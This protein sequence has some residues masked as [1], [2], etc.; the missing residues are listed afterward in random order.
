MK[1]LAVKEPWQMTKKEYVLKPIEALKEQEKKEIQPFSEKIYGR[2]VT[3]Y[4]T[5]NYKAVE[6]RMEFEHKQA[7]QQSLSEGKP[8]PPEVLED[9]PDLLYE[10]GFKEVFPK[11]V[12]TPTRE[13]ME[14]NPG[15]KMIKGEEVADYVIGLGED[16]DSPIIDQI[17]K[18]GFILKTLNIQDI[19]NNDPHVAKVV[20]TELSEPFSYKNIDSP[21]VINSKGEVLDGEHRL[22]AKIKQGDATINAYI[23]QAKRKGHLTKEYRT[24]LSAKYAQEA[25]EEEFKKEHLK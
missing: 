17:K 21:I 5:A 23:G 25:E 11:G 19:L 4:E 18:E 9:Y 15:A 14:T 8:V 20:K 7:I 1:H 22:Q 12:P 6:K 13:Q 24:A 10:K 2:P 3:Y 16:P